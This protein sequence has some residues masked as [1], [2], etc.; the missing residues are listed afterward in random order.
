MVL[1]KAK[2]ALE[3]E[4]QAILNV[5]Q[6]LDDRFEQAVDLI[7]NCKGR[8]V[9]TGMGK[10]GLVCKKIS[11]TLAS[12]GTPSFFLHPAEAIHGDLGMIVRGDII[13]AASYSGETEE[14]KRLLPIV[15]RFDLKLIS[16]TAGKN[17]TMAKYSD[18]VLDIMVSEEACPLNLAPTTS[19]TVTLAIGDAL[20]IALLDKRGFRP[21]D[22]AAFHPG[23]NLGKKL[24]QV[25]ELMHSGSQ[26]PVVDENVSLKDTLLEMSAKKF[27]ISSVID[28]TGTLVG[29]ITD[30]DIRR[31]M[32]KDV[33]L[34]N[35]P[36]KNSMTKNP[37]LINQQDLAAKALE[38]M[39]RYSI[40]ALL[41][42]DD[43]RHPRGVLH[44]HDL[45]KAGVV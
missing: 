9:V 24:I 42:I 45:L 29:I 32:I 43:N 17:S 23:G 38:E 14:I 39:E 33:N 18:V 44:L 2:E 31:I 16:I 3:K 12:T 22:F 37:R 11:A 35:Q 6:H 20:A 10:S 13:L 7:Y 19:T 25:S 4:A 28:S 5:A 1:K 30:G 15:K 27:G 26:V 8:V 34:L 40:T 41:I 21:E 36:V